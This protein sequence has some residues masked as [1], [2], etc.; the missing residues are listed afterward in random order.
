MAASSQATTSPKPTAGFRH[1]AW[2]HSTGWSVSTRFAQRRQRFSFP[3]PVAYQSQ[4]FIGQT[5]STVH[6]TG[7]PLLQVADSNR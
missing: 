2:M 4:F 7:G 1:L 3:R 6:V 5:A